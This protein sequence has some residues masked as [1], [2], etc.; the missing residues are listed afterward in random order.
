EHSFRPGLRRGRV[1]AALL[2]P[3]EH[4]GG[5]RAAGAR[6]GHLGV[7]Q[8][9]V[10]LG[11]QL[12]GQDR[13]G[14]R[15]GMPGQMR[16]DLGLLLLVLLAG[17]GVPAAAEDG[18]A[19]ASRDL[20]RD[21]WAVVVPDHWRRQRHRL[22]RARLADRGGPAGLGCGHSQRLE[23]E[24]LGQERAREGSAP[25]D[26]PGHL[27]RPRRAVFGGPLSRLHLQ[28]R[29]CACLLR[30]RAPAGVRAGDGLGV[31][32]AL[33]LLLLD[34]PRR[35]CRGL[36]GAA[37]TALAGA[38]PRSGAGTGSGPGRARGP[39]VRPSG[40]AAGGARAA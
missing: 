13:G 21:L 6:G 33:G 35:G 19:E 37:G 16:E 7:R 11:S 32:R 40:L 39:L 26:Y 25:R 27:N 4:A 28:L 3:G 23:G 8:S 34:R 36:G 22:A 5:A 29:A 17:Q 31:A 10:P 14:E 12:H 18:Q 9:G 20:P 15:R 30:G 38:C 24:D 1:R 2:R